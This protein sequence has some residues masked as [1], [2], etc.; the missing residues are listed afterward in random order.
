MEF[1]IKGESRNSLNRIVR[2]AG[3]LIVVVVVAVALLLV[4]SSLLVSSL[5]LS[6]SSY[7]EINLTFS[8][9]INDGLRLIL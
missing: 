6:S 8:S 4:D 5:E 9:F 3:A 1:R 2:T 7:I